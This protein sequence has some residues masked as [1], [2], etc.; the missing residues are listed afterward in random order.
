VAWR[1]PHGHIG[2]RSLSGRGLSVW[3]E[4]DL[5]RSFSCGWR[6][7]AS[8]NLDGP[9]VRLRSDISQERSDFPWESCCHSANNG[10]CSERLWV[11]ESG[12]AS[13]PWSARWQRIQPLPAPKTSVR[14]RQS[15]SCDRCRESRW[16]ANEPSAAPSSLPPIQIRYS[17]E[18]TQRF[19]AVPRAKSGVIRVVL[20]EYPRPGGPRRGPG[21]LTVREVV[22]PESAA[23]G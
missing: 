1:S 21:H 7:L 20:S 6:V 17:H 5:Q 12:S 4:A 14:A 23:I 11:R 22:I 10:R 13:P 15:P 9:S 19:S 16:K 2:L 18:T 8:R 3:V